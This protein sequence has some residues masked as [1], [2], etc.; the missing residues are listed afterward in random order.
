MS[1]FRCLSLPLRAF[2]YQAKHR[3]WGL[4]D[5]SSVGCLVL[6]R[7]A[8]AVLHRQ[9]IEL[10]LLL[11]GR[12][13]C[14]CWQA[15]MQYTQQQQQRQQRMYVPPNPPTY[16]SGTWWK[17]NVLWLAT[18]SRFPSPFPEPTGLLRF[19]ERR[20]IKDGPTK[21]RQRINERTEELLLKINH[22]FALGNFTCALQVAQVQVWDPAKRNVALVVV[23]NEP[24]GCVCDLREMRSKLFPPTARAAETS[25]IW[26]A[27]L[28]FDFALVDW[29]GLQI[30]MGKYR[31]VGRQGAATIKWG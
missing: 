31:T 1:L 16:Y 13:W 25:F 29:N 20:N 15:P 21:G 14:W 8:S 4:V 27:F 26:D 2:G 24:L 17:N 5:P 12:S 6:G 7:L 23:E 22:L 11:V 30:M 18:D 9:L 28:F 3:L 19:A 10:E